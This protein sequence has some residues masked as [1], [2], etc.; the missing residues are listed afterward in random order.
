MKSKDKHAAEQIFKNT[1]K[2]QHGHPH[3]V[4]VIVDWL[5][6]VSASSAPVETLQK[7]VSS[8]SG[9]LPFESRQLIKMSDKGW[10]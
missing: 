7:L 6:T 4:I 2:Q 10:G 9:C 1:G 3:P 5:H 8:A